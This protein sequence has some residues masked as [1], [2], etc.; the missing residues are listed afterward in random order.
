[1]TAADWWKILEGDQTQA[2]FAADWFEEGGII[3][4]SALRW[5]VEKGVWPNYEAPGPWAIDLQI[6]KVWAWWVNSVNQ[7]K[8]LPVEL[9]KRMPCPYHV[10]TFACKDYRDY[11]TLE[12][13]FTALAVAL[14]QS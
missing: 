1:M 4:G 8:N 10:Q 3:E 14:N 9:F 7:N 12:E 11:L 2:H 5:A 6:E 13:A